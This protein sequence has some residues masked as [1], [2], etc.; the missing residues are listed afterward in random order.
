M[1]FDQLKQAQ[2]RMW[3][4]GPFE[5]MEANL[6]DMHDALVAS[7]GP[8][9]DEAWLDL[10][11]GTGGVASR[12]A[13]AGAKVTG[14]DLAP[15]LIETARRRAAEAGLEI[16]YEVGDAEDLRFD[17]GAFNA[18]TSSVGVIFAPRH[19]VAAAELARVC[20]PGGRIAISAWRPDGGVGDFFRFM[21]GYQPPVPEGVGNPLD[22]GVEENARS[23]L[24]Q[25]FDLEIQTLD[26]PFLTESGEAMWDLMS[27]AFGP[28]RTL[29]ASMDDSARAE[30]R[31][32]FI[33]FAEKDRE[34]EVVRQSRTYLLIQGRR[35]W[36]HA[37]TT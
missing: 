14:V 34:G 19:Q 22:W 9:P 6:A 3:G 13:A 28:T 37:T 29:A 8:K 24:G 31:E 5:E 11:C 2:G 18:I 7:I 12:A 4:S 10:G 23:L 15:A 17:D 26:S 25:S 27:R 20:A 35:H 33:E 36:P 30:F 16:E 1:D 32:A 21:R